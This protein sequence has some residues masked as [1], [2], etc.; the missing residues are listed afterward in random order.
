MVNCIRERKR[1]GNP[2][3]FAFGKM[4]IHTDQISY[5]RK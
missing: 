2:E 1:K 5:L 4:A 3:I